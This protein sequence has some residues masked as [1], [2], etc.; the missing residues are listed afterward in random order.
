[1]TG[2]ARTLAACLA[3]AED[4]LHERPVDLTDL[5]GEE[6]AAVEPYTHGWRLRVGS[7]RAI[8]ILSGCTFDPAGNPVIEP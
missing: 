3:S 4:E 7:G 5:V 6:I 2:G 1:M 8:V